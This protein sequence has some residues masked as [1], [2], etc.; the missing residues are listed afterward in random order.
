[1]SYNQIIKK[2]VLGTIIKNG[3]EVSLSVATET[4]HWKRP[5]FI[6][7]TMKTKVTKAVM[8]FPGQLPA[9]TGEVCIRYMRH[10]IEPLT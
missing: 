3:K 7:D 5:E 9:G 10:T 6:P 1:M 8:D 2:Q 4:T